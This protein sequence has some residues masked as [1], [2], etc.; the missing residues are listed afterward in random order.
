MWSLFNKNVLRFFILVVVAFTF[1][2]HC[3]F[4]QSISNYAR[5]IG[6]YSSKDSNQFIVLRTFSKNHVGY[7]LRVNVKTLVTDIWPYFPQLVV[8]A[9][10][11]ELKR[12]YLGSTYISALQH[13]E[14]NSKVIQD[15]GILHSLNKEKGAVLTIDLCPSKK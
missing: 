13:A 8:P 9:S 3:A 6:Y 7:C 10:L 5:Y 2:I 11:F 1:S 12:K 15:A 4:T 14:L